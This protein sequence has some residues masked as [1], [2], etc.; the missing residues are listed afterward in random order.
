[1]LR[2]LYNQAGRQACNLK[3]S[4]NWGGAV[5]QWGE[6]TS[7][8]HA[9]GFQ[10]NPWYSQGEL[11]KTHHVNAWR[12]PV[13]VDP[14]EVDKLMSNSDGSSVCWSSL[15]RKKRPRSDFGIVLQSP[16]LLVCL[17]AAWHIIL[18]EGTVQSRLP[19][20]VQMEAHFFKYKEDTHQPS[21]YKYWAVINAFAYK[22]DMTFFKHTVHEI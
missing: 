21:S 14:T 20:H 9:E 18:W 10:F 5:A 19:L 2:K 12:M 11:G 13:N 6:K 22:E 15:E 17:M 7:A 8:L 1:M 4:H 16:S 3:T